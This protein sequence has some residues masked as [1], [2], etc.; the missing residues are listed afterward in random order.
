MRRRT[1]FAI[2]AA[3]GAA[4]IGIAATLPGETLAVPALAALP[5]SATALPLD[6]DDP[7]RDRI[8]ALR[9]MG[10]LQ[11]RSSNPLFGGISGLRAGTGTRMLAESDTGNWIAF[12]TV[13]RDGG[14]VAVANAVIAPI[15]RPD[16]RPAIDKPD[17]DAEALEWN[18]ATGDATIAYEQDHRLTHFT[19]IDADRP[20]TLRHRPVATERFAETR[21][22]RDNGGGETLAVLPGGARVWIREDGADDHF[23]TALLT[24]GGRTRTIR[25]AAPAGF[26]PTDAV[27]LDATQLLVVNRRF[28]PADGL[29]AALTLV[30]LAPSL[31]GS[32]PEVPAVE[33]ARWHSPVAVDNMEALAL[34]REGGRVFV[35]IASDDNLNG[36][37]RTLLMKFELQLP[38]TR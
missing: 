28:N 15:L 16:G 37:Q 30:D 23:H 32:G 22:W 10:A 35:Y 14:L 7:A 9:F 36:L 31:A 4:G 33:L 5:L 8:G 6:R 17:G 18:P 1:I 27:A 13:E 38:R 3:A 34:R 24:L 25:I 19:G 11:L 21:D 12:D 2:A 26:S 29:L 20:E